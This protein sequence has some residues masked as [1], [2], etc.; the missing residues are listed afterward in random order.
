MTLPAGATASLSP[1]ST[2]VSE[3]YRYTLQAPPGYP[4]TE[5]KALEDWVVE[6]QFRTVPGVVDVSGFRRTDQAVPGSCRSAQAQELSAYP[7]TGHRRAQFQQ[8]ERGRRLRRT[9]L[10]DVHCARPGLDRQLGRYPLDR[11]GRAQQHAHHRRRPGA[12]CVSATNSGWDASDSTSPYPTYRL[13]VPTGTTWYR[14]PCSHA[15]V[16]T[17]WRCSSSSR[18]RRIRSTKTTCRRAYGW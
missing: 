9:R 14:A 12:R 4:L 11:A 1:D 7:Q 18:P 3:I 2:A 5:L 8:P 16:R 15:G 13:R 17:R 10:A 6:R